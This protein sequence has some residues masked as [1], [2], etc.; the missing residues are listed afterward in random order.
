MQLLGRQFVKE[1]VRIALLHAREGKPSP[2]RFQWP[3]RSR[4]GLRPLFRFAAELQHSRHVLQVFRPRLD[5]FGIGPHVIIAVRQSQ[6]S[7]SGKRNHARG[8]RIILAELKPNSAVS[9]ER[10]WRDSNAGR[11]ASDLSAAYL[12]QVRLQRRETRLFHR[13]F[14]HARVVIVADFGFH[15]TA[16]GRGLGGF[17]QNSPEKPPVS[18]RR[19]CRKRPSLAGQMASDSS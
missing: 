14:I 1:L 5:R 15:L 11:S 12:G 17:L 19:A 18:L 8:I 6:A 7:S 13:G 2:A 9:P 3:S 16:T 10:C 4:V